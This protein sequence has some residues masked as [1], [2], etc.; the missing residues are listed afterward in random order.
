MT[1]FYNYYPL[2]SF[3]MKIHAVYYEIQRHFVTQNLFIYRLT[4]DY[5]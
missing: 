5:Y 4:N 1:L 2:K 3:F